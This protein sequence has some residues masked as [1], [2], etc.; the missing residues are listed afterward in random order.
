MQRTNRRA[1]VVG[2]AT[3]Q[4]EKQH[5]GELFGR[6]STQGGFLSWHA[7]NAWPIHSSFRVSKR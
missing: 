5:R 4:P 3:G 6:Y 1:D 2:A 7:D